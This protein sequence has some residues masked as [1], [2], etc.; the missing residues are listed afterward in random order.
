MQGVHSRGKYHSDI[1]YF[2]QNTTNP[3][4]SRLGRSGGCGGQ[5]D[6]N[7]KRYLHQ[8]IIH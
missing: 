3:G 6:L 8:S 4:T 2:S 5:C 7:V 1:H